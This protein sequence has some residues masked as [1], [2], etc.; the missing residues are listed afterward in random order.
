MNQ[1]KTVNERQGCTIELIRE[2]MDKLK[3]GFNPFDKMTKIRSEYEKK[4]TLL[5]ALD[6]A[7]SHLSVSDITRKDMPLR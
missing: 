3:R 4:I 5:Q 1:Y 7:S 6:L 2:E